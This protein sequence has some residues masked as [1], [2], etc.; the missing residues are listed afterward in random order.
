MVWISINFLKY[1]CDVWLGKEKLEKIIE[2]Q[3]GTQNPA[4]IYLLK[5]KNRDPRK[6]CEMRSKFINKDTRTTSESNTQKLNERKK[7]RKI[8]W[9]TVFSNT[10]NSSM[11]EAVMI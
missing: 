8:P 10:F 4:D 2:R 3:L 9:I 6:R 1:K 11:T 5:V 7:K